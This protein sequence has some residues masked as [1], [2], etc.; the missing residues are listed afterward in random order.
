M[1][2]LLVEDTWSDI[3]L[4]IL[5]LDEGCWHHHTEVIRFGDEAMKYLHREGR[6]CNAP[7][8]DLV[9]LDLELPRKDGRQVLVE[10]KTNEDLCSIPVVIMTLSDSVKDILHG[11]EM[12]VV[13]YITKPVDW[14]KFIDI[15]RDF[16]CQWSDE[17]L[18]PSEV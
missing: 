15:V 6:Y 12:D 10:I 3:G 7:R 4:T 8:P 11:S 2:I 17:V 16:K 14:D 1:E 5:A 9:L 18:L 13:A